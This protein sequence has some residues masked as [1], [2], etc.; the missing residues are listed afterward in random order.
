[1]KSQVVAHNNAWLIKYR[2]N[3]CSQYG[4]DGVTEKVLSVM[5]SSELDNWAVEL[6]A[7]DGRFASNICNLL[8]RGPPFWNGVFIEADKR[9]FI[10][11][12]RNYMD[13]P[14]VHCLNRFVHWEGRDSLDSTNALELCHYCGINRTG[15][16]RNIAAK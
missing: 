10:D 12:K 6:G 5:H 4:E 15:A 8:R 14:R 7:W 2:K 11:L 9:R 16:H 1:M 3:V 13:N